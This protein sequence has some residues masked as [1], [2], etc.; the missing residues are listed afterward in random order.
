MLMLKTDSQSSHVMVMSDFFGRVLASVAA[1]K[2][3]CYCCCLYSNLCIEAM[4][5]DQGS[6]K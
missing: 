2:S 4:A 5:G 1:L 6:Q 3:C